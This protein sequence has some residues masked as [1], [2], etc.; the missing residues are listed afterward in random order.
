M[1]QLYTGA[2]GDPLRAIAVGD[3]VCPWLVH[4]VG[5]GGRLCIGVWA[6]PSWIRCG[7]TLC[8]GLVEFVLGCDNYILGR[9]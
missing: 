9:L 4:F 2:V 7:A 3:F 5:G 6:T 1:R 8:V